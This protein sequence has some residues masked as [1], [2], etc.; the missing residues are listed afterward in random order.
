MAGKLSQYLSGKF[1]IKRLGRQ[2]NHGSPNKRMVSQP[3]NIP[4]NLRQ[5][6]TKILHPR[7]KNTTDSSG[8]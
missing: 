6:H 8:N 2:Y 7:T 3:I 5:E 4:A 1:E